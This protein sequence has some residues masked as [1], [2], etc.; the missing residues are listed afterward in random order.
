MTYSVPVE[1]HDEAELAQVLSQPYDETIELMKRLEGDIIILGVA[2]KMGP[3]LAHLAR[4][5]STAA[6]VQRRII[7][8]ARFSDPEQRNRLDALGVETIACDLSDPEAVAKLPRVANVIFMAGRKFG[9]VGSEPL[10][11]IMNAVVPA[12]VARHFVGSRTVA[13]STG[14]VYPLS[15]HEDGGCNEYVAPAPTGEYAN[16]CLGRERIFEHYA[17]A[18]HTPTLLYRLNYAID[19]RYGVLNDVADQVWNDRPVDMTVAWANVIWQGDAN[20]RALLCLEHTGVPA[21]ALNIT[22]GEM[23][24]IA[25]V[26][27]DFGRRWNKEVTFTGTPTGKQY[28]SDASRSME[29]FG[30]PRVSFDRLM[31]WTAD[32]FVRGGARINKPTHFTVTDGQF[33]D[34]KKER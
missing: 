6:G 13:F 7:G 25:D 18:R 16:S 31:D 15:G 28:L 12:I 5:A 21:V 26:A 22:G 4:R 3:S 20:N 11:W 29:L 27:R 17:A 1:I 30:P 32:W 24:S 9:D 34:S 2:G 14:C 10:T 19:L 8:V 33:L 23:I